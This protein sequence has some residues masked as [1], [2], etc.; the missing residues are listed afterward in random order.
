MPVMI[1]NNAAMEMYITKGQEGVVHAWD[2]HKATDGK[3]ILDTLFVKLTNPTTPVKLSGL[4][5]NVVPLTG[6]SVTTCCQLPDD[7]S[8]TVSQNQIEALL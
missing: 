3:D 4:P 1:H 6:T 2:S 8:L 7:S 5:L